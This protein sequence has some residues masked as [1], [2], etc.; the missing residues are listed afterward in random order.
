MEPSTSPAYG[1]GDWWR[2]IPPCSCSSPSTSSSRRRDWRSFGA[3][4]AFIVALFAEMYGFPL[5]LYLLSGGL[6]TRYPALDLFT[7]DAGHLWWTLAGQHGDP[8][9]AGTH[10][11]SIAFIAAGFWLLAAAWQALHAAQQAGHLAM[12]GPHARV[13]H[14]QY[15]AF[16]LILFGFLLQWP[17]LLTIAMFPVLLVMYPRL[18]RSEERDCERAFGPQWQAYARA[19]PRFI[20]SWRAPPS[21]QER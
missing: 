18:A 4:T 10:P 5:T 1:C 20:P 13:R 3:F 15:V 16:V 6:Q 9:T 11:L 8:H 2:S 14:P 19:T 7:H 17:T 12:T 21:P